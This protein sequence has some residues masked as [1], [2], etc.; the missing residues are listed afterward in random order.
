MFVMGIARAQSA[1]YVLSFA[2]VPR[3]ELNYY[4]IRRVKFWPCLRHI[5]EQ[6]R[7]LILTI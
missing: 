6:I 5:W 2:V 1:L 3:L 4:Y 7:R